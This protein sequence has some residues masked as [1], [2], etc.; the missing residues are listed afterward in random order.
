M[1]FLQNVSNSLLGD[2]KVRTTKLA[3][4]GQIQHILNVD[5]TGAS[6]SVGLPALGQATAANSLPVV[7][8]SNASLPSG[9]NA[10]G[11]LSGN[12]GINIGTVDVVTLPSDFGTVSDASNIAGSMMAKLRYIGTAPTNATTTAGYVSSLL[13]KASAG[14]LYGVSGYNSK[15]SGQ[16]IQISDKNST[17]AD[18]TGPVVII[19]VEASSNWF[20]DPGPKGR[21]FATGIFICCSSTGPTKTIG[22]AD[23]WIDAQYS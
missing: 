20:Y 23:I 19:W 9:T 22:S 8:A 13:V 7:W 1:A 18:G 6:L 10:I 4:G 15:T 12:N 14:T 17:P 2:Y 3:D 11:R 5:D 21:S 16:F